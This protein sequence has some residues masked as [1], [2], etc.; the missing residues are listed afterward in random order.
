[1]IKTI[2]IAFVLILSIASSGLCLWASDPLL[3]AKFRADDA[4]LWHVGDNPAMWGLGDTLFGEGLRYAPVGTDGNV[5]D[6]SSS[7]P[8]S[9]GVYDLIVV[10]PIVNFSLT[11]RGSTIYSKLGVTLSPTK[12]FAFGSQT[13]QVDNGATRTMTQDLGFLIRPFDFLSVGLTGTDIF[14]TDRSLGMGLGFRPLALFTDEASWLTLTADSHADI[15]GFAFETAGARINIGSGLSLRGWWDFQSSQPGAEISFSYSGLA[16]FLSS[17]QLGEPWGNVRAGVGALVTK[18]GK[19]ANALGRKILVLKDYDSVT[20]TPPTKMSLK[21]PWDTKKTIDIA[22][23]CA[24]LRR[25]ALDPTVAA[26]AFED[27]PT[28]GREAA[29]QELAQAI[30][31]LRSAHKKLYVYADMMDSSQQYESLLSAADSISLNPLGS[32]YLTGS[33][34]PQLYLKDFFDKLGVKFINLALWDTKS[35]YNGLTR[36]SMPEGERA[37]IQ[38]YIDELQSQADAALEANRGSKLRSPV[39][40]IV[41]KGPYL[42]AGTALDA[43]LVDKLEYRADFEEDLEEEYKGAKIVDGLGDP[44]ADSWG[45]SPFAKKVAVVWLTG[46]VVQGKGTVGSEIGQNAALTLKRLRKDP[47]VS[48]ILL[49][50]DSGGGSAMTSDII[51][52]QVKKTVAAGKSVIVSMGDVAASGGYYISAYASRVFALPGTITGSIGVTGLLFDLTELE[53]KLGI[54]AESVVTSPNANFMSPFLPTKDSDKETMLASIGSVYDRFVSVVAEGR[55]LDPETV[56][57]LGEG[58]IWIGRE[59]LANGLVDQLGGLEDAKAYLKTKL[60]GRVQFEDVFPGA[61]QV[62]DGSTIL[63]TKAAVDAMSLRP[64]AGAEEKL[65]SLISPTALKL[66]SMLDMGQGPLY[67]AELGD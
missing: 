57:K 23:L 41:A 58:Q 54:K 10:S 40:E 7:G 59:A 48:A 26:V 60:G 12:W 4:S 53:S 35:A 27:L 52:D 19:T 46:S 9:L 25:A 20:D 21:M 14:N 45:S 18:E 38:R 32:L 15:S 17:P 61:D 30:G 13:D 44:S 5:I 22:S 65:W 51:A 66:S 8:D 28:V 56:R 50:V 24:L 43:G 34:G 67:L 47:T 2:K 63:V 55:K 49:R 1:V 33:G 6:M 42:V 16:G 62:L 3:D 39:K 29:Q 11:Q 36:D 31:V 64:R 37:M